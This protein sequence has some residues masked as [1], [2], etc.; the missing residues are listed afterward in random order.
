MKYKTSWQKS[1]LKKFGS[2]QAVKAEMSRRQTMS[3]QGYNGN[4]Q[5][6][7]LK[8]RYGDDYFSK[9]GKKGGESVSPKVGD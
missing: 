4:K 5:A 9:I 7:T 1:M 2:E 3:R 6:K 8:E